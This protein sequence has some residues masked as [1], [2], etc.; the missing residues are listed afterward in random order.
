VAFKSAKKNETIKRSMNGGAPTEQN[1]R[2]CPRFLSRTSE[3]PVEAT[4]GLGAT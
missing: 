3:F 1:I 4:S 2:L